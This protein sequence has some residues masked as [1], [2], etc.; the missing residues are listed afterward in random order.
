MLLL[1]ADE[2]R[3]LDR[4]TIESG[5]AAGE[6]LMERAGVGVVDAME[7]HHGSLLAMRVLVL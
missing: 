6:A 1:T 4:A 3:R 2:M 5:H 7:R